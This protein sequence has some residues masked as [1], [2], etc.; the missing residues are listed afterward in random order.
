MMISIFRWS[1]INTHTK[2]STIQRTLNVGRGVAL[3]LRMI[4]RCLGCVR[5]AFGQ[6]LMPRC[7]RREKRRSVFGWRT[8]E[9]SVILSWIHSKKNKINWINSSWIPLDRIWIAS[10]YFSCE[11]FLGGDQ[12]ITQSIWK[13]DLWS[14]VWLQRRRCRYCWRISREYLRVSVLGLIFIT[15]WT[16]ATTS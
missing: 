2:I 3:G 11:K 7:L 10:M 8:R 13:D 6:L 16:S 1:S 14:R 15:G 9:R 4:R 12:S 5:I